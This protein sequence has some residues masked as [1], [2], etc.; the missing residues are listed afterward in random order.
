MVR[1]RWTTGP[2]FDFLSK[3]IDKFME[4]QEKNELQKFIRPLFQSFVNRFPIKP[5]KEQIREAGGKQTVAYEVR[6]NLTR[7][8]S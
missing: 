1:A 7:K 4:A 3:E 6:K 8:V 5:T 2:E